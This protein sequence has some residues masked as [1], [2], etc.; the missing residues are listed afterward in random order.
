MNDGG[1]MEVMANALQPFADHAEFY[2]ECD[3]HPDGCP[4]NLTAG[5]WTNPVTV[6]D[7]RRAAEAIAA[8]N[9]RAD[10]KAGEVAAL[11]D[12][13]WCFD[14]SQ[15]HGINEVAGTR[16]GLDEGHEGECVTHPRHDPVSSYTLWKDGQP[17]A[18]LATIDRVAQAIT[19]AI[20]AQDDIGGHVR[21]EDGKIAY[22]DQGE[23]DMRA[24]SIAAIQAFLRGGG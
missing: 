16:C 3:D 4:D 21:L 5:G 8:W 23:T 15:M 18:S 20:I 17:V 19:D 22:L 13:P 24:V 14:M 11:F 12:L 7:Y 9:A 1:L 2:D 6:G 10:A